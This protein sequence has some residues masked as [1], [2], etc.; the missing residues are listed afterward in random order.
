MEISAKCV[1]FNFKT[2]NGDYFPAE[3]LSFR[4]I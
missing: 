3:T 2:E 4:N 1:R